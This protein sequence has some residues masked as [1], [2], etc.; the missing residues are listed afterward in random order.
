MRASK[1]L[2]GLLAFGVLTGPAL[3]DGHE[4]D[5]SRKFTAERVFDI[6]YAADPQIS[7]DGRTIVYVRRSMD[8]L[9]DQDRGDIWTLDVRSGAHRPLITGGASAGAPRWS[10]DGSQLIYT[11][12]T[13]GTN[14]LHHVHAQRNAELRQADRSTGRRRVVSPRPRV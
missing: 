9:K 14:R 3:A 4:E 2:G 1:L 6:E 5:T 12:A 10:P 8:K 11:T 13:D 7:P